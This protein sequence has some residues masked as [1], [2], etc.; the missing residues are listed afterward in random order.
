MNIREAIKKKNKI[1]G[2]LKAESERLAKYNSVNVGYKRPY[3]PMECYENWMRLTNE[4]IELKAKIHEANRAVYDLIFRM[5]E[6]KHQATILEK[7]NCRDGV[8]EDGYGSYTREYNAVFNI[9][10]RD[11]MVVAIREEIESIQDRLD[12]HNNST[13]I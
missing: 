13:Y 7:M 2:K 3:D 12:K 10:T 11:K 8:D 4:L 1:V 6:L 5:S 9:V